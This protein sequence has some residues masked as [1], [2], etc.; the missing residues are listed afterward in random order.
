MN[1]QNLSNQAEPPL[2]GRSGVRVFYPR[3]VD[4]AALRIDVKS[5]NKGKQSLNVAH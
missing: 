3:H 5:K 1:K 2:T 4:I